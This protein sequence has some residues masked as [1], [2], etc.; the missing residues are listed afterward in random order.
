MRPEWRSIESSRATVKVY[1]TGQDPGID[2]T[3]VMDDMFVEEGKKFTYTYRGGDGVTKVAHPQDSLQLS[4]S[5]PATLN[6][7]KLMIKLGEH[8]GKLRRAATDFSQLCAL[9][10]Q[11][12]LG[13]IPETPY[14]CGPIEDETRPLVNGLLKLHDFHL[15]TDNSQPYEHHCAFRFGKK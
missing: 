9:N 15:L 11:F 5:S 8:Y 3:T 2:C 7:E 10:R 12:L 14:H 1:L 6:F 4:T 13:K